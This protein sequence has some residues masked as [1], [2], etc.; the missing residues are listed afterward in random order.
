M[1]TRVYVRW[2]KSGNQVHVLEVELPMRPGHY[3]HAIETYRSR[4]DSNQ[5]LDTGLLDEAMRKEYGVAWRSLT[6]GPRE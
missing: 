5:Y 4:L 2:R 3:L 6:P 1:R